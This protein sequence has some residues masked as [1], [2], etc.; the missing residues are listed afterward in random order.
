MNYRNFIPILVIWIVSCSNNLKPDS[1]RAISVRQISPI[2][3][4]TG[5][6]AWYDS[7][8]INIYYWKN[9]VVYDIGYKFDSIVNDQY[10]KQETRRYYIVFDTTEKF[11][12]SY[13]QHKTPVK[14]KIN[15][16][17][18][19]QTLWLE[20]GDMY[21]FLTDNKSTLLS[22]KSN[23]DS[24]TF[25]ESYEMI[26]NIDSNFKSRGY[27]SYTNGLR[28]VHIKYSRKLDSLKNM[29]LY[30]AYIHTPKQFYKQFNLTLDEYFYQ[31]DLKELPVSDET[32]K[33]ILK[34]VTE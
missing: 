23:K 1:I 28:N 22:S 8:V 20:S 25:H 29:R 10:L 5:K 31:F 17:S 33:L 32:R 24:G 2:V 7:A 14:T 16:D 19:F 4:P 11:A 21:Q 9:K 6:V 12:F 30:H 26:N 34:Y 13:D 3:T 27:F 18:L 15:R